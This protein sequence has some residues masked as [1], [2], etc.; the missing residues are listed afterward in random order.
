MS[1]LAIA[2]IVIGIIFTA[3]TFYG[4]WYCAT[5]MF[6]RDISNTKRIRYLLGLV[7]SGSLLL[8]YL[9][10]Y[11]IVA[12]MLE[13]DWLKDNLKWLFF[14]AILVVAVIPTLRIRTYR[15]HRLIFDVLKPII[16]FLGVIA[17]IGLF[18]IKVFG[19]PY[20]PPLDFS[21]NAIV[22]DMLYWFFQFLPFVVYPSVVAFSIG[23]YFVKLKQLEDSKQ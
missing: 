12:E 14:L 16:N 10:I 6:E 18:L 8:E 7:G 1:S 19:V 23:E 9:S 2:L 22:N 17:T 4:Q 11:I 5:N 15:E 21:F 3:L 20:H 13:L